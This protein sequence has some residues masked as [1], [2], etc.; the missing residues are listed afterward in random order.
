[1][2]VGGGIGGGEH[3]EAVWP[4]ILGLIIV[5]LVLAFPHGIAGFAQRRF[6]RAA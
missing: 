6:G 2:R 5:L 4:L 3:P 1:L